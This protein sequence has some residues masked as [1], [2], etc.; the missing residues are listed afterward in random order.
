[1]GVQFNYTS[2][3][4]RSS[5]SY[6]ECDAK[7]GEKLV[8]RHAWQNKYYKFSI[9]TRATELVER[10]QSKDKFWGG[11]LHSSKRDREVAIVGKG[12]KL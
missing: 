6:K 12:K 4:Q 10:R 9:E 8:Q 5:I 2:T 1:L 11:R 7:G 3:S